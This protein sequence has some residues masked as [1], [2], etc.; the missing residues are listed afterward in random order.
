VTY[1]VAWLLVADGLGVLQKLLIYGDFQEQSS[2]VFTENGWKK[3]KRKYPVSCSAVSENALL[4]PGVRGKPKGLVR[5]DWK[6]TVSQ[7]TCFNQGLRRSISE[8]TRQTLNQ[9]GYTKQ[10]LQFTQAHQNQ[11]TEDWKTV[12]WSE[13]S[14]EYTTKSWQYS[15]DLQSHQISIH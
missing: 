3:R 10:R 9:L 8:H 4:L 7:I 14:W 15:N 11:T 6:T 1:N 12:A 2:L 13:E 5:A